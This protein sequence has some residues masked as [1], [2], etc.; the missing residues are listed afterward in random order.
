M[1]TSR[2]SR[3]TRVPRR[4]GA[5][6]AVGALALALGGCA[7]TPDPLSLEQQITQAA[8]DRAVMYAS[9]EP[10]S[11]AVTLEE[12]LARAIKYNLDHRVAL[13]QRALE[14]RALDVAT[15]DLLPEVVGRAG[16]R[17]RDNVQASSSRSIVSGRQSLEPSTSTE[18]VLRTADLQASLSTLDFGLSYFGAKA[19][20]NRL[21]AAEQQ[22]RRI[23]I[24]IA[25]QVRAAYWEAVTAEQLQPRVARAL[26]EARQALSF[27]RQAEDERLLPPLETLQFQRALLEI[28]QQLEVVESEL[29]IAKAQ[30]AGLMN[31]PPGIRF[32][33]AAPRRALPARL[34]YRL[35]DLEAVAMVRRPEIQ[36]ELYVARNV[37]LETRSEILRL[38]PGLSL[39]GG[40]NSDSNDFLVNNSWADAGVSVTWNLLRLV[41]VPSIL[42][43]GEAREELAETR[44]LALR[45]AVLTQ[46]NLAYRRYQRA[47]RLYQRS[48]SIEQVE[49]RI[50][51]AT[52]SAEEQDASNLL[53][54]VRAQAASVLATRARNRAFAEVQNALGSVYAAAGFDPLPT[55]VED[56]D[57]RTLAEAIAAMAARIDAGRIELP[58]V[59]PAQTVPVAANAPAAVYAAIPPARPAAE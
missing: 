28:V 22:R 10:V 55:T 31:L 25:D 30:L 42:A 4:A 50:A 21:L 32:T 17:T 15:V 56:G 20:A 40:V 6:G 8:Q 52:R 26:A 29:A 19:Q 59:P 11:G 37:V 44:R 13:M 33:L 3:A 38:L 53:E 39:F 23:V 35:D 48:A 57:L 7:I 12:A 58:T 51:Q 5:L 1:V 45:M 14:D 34:P 49:Q 41:A 47:Q 27:A 2:P 24:D 18:E 16:Y 9:Q 54:R 36:E 43:A 46:V